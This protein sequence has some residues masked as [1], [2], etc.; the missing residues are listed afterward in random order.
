MYYFPPEEAGDLLNADPATIQ[1]S[2]TR[3]GFAAKTNT[4]RQYVQVD[5]P[6]RQCTAVVVR[7]GL[8]GAVIQA[9]RTMRHCTRSST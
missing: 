5:D 7:S 4:K 2:R 3:A 6:A 9:V 1:E 8:K